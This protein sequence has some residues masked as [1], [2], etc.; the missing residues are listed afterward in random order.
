M[1]CGDVRIDGDGVVVGGLGYF[2][3]VSRF[4]LA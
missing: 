2:W 1:L 4:L 3:E